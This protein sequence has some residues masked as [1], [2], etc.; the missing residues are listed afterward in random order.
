MPIPASSSTYPWGPSPISVPLSHNGSRARRRIAPR[1]NR[2]QRG[3]AYSRKISI[4]VW[5]RTRYPR[6]LHRSWNGY[7]IPSRSPFRIGLCPCETYGRA[8]PQSPLGESAS[9][10]ARPRGPPHLV[11]VFYVILLT[12]SFA[13]CCSSR[14]SDEW[15][16]R[17]PRDGNASYAANGKRFI[18]RGF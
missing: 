7:P 15:N 2:E 10:P 18:Q 4:R 14:S 11:W 13:L 5:D 6:C 16:V 17:T 9:Q 8:V 12:P 3:A 1:A